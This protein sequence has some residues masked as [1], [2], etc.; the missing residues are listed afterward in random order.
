MLL[1]WLDAREATAAGTALADDFY[2]QSVENLPRARPKEG[3]KGAPGPELQRF[4]QRFLQR[5]DQT[6]RPLSL[7]L[8]KRAKL[9]NSFKWRL[10]EKGVDKELVDELTGAL[11]QRLSASGV[12]PAGSV[13]VTL[14]S[15]GRR[16]QR[17]FAA[18]M[19]RAGE[20]AA[21][22][23]HAE[24]VTCYQEALELDARNCIVHNNLGVSLCAVGR[25]AEALHHYRR[26]IGIKENYAD[27]QLNLGSL[28]RTLGQ[29]IESEQPLRRALKLKPALSEAQI[30]LAGTLFSLG[31]L[32][33]AQQLLERTLKTAP[34]HV[35][36]LQIMGQLVARQGR[37][38]EAEG[39]FDGA[40][41]IDP[42][43][44]H[45]WTGLAALRRM[46]SVDSMWL[47]GAE[48]CAD[49]GRLPPLNEASVRYAI[50]KYY[51][52]VG[53]FGRAFRS[54]QLAK[55]LVKTAA[56]PYD[57]AGATRFVDDLIR[58]YPRET[59]VQPQ[60][61][62]SDSTTPVIVVGMPRSGT[63]L[64]AQIIGSHPAARA[65]GEL[66]YWSY[67][68]RKHNVGTR[69]EAPGETTRRRLAE[70]YLR[71][72]TE[73]CEDAVRVVDKSPFNSDYLGI[74]HTVFPNARIIYLQRDPIDTCLSCYFQDFPPAL[75]FT[76]DLSDLAHFYREHRRVFEHWRTALPPGTLLEVPYEELISDQEGWTRRI[77]E[78]LGLPWDAHCL[79][80][81]ETK[82]SVLTA[83]YWQVRQKI[84]NRSVGRW[85][86]YRKFIGP[87]LEL[88]RHD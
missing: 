34:R 16:D 78:F 43:A 53:D 82:R 19:Q 33:E 81:Y 48:Q 4:L 52:D 46:T 10:L 18:L 2:L 69:H 72:L 9:A 26:A 57:R 56:A 7:N 29:S 3:S 87:L 75:N 59:L 23:A 44:S 17:Y 55:E 58:A 54:C 36:A 20:Y 76:L 22:G 5:V 67:A 13:E 27:A 79:S 86:N 35:E 31:R 15:K 80:F 77:L 50:A 12:E 85:R 41:E 65:A 64:L 14:P 21:R 47:K 39:W 73:G 24:A 11:V 60:A 40:L 70:R 68:V 62:A 45:A 84:Y 49:S 83:S 32:D 61:G 74:I 37:F 88:G 51:D 63:T 25:Y 8:L 71:V 6:A 30:S 28:L 1:K 66:E 38:A 42:N